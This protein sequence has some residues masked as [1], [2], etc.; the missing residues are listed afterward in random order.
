MLKIAHVCGYSEDIPTEAPPVAVTLASLTGVKEFDLL[1]F[2]L[3]F[4]LLGINATGKS[5]MQTQILHCVQVDSTSGRRVN[6]MSG[7][8]GVADVCGLPTPELPFT[9]HLSVAE[10]LWPCSRLVEFP[11]ASYRL[12]HFGPLFCRPDDRHRRA[13]R[14]S[15][16]Q[17]TISGC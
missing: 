14:C 11:H 16:A 2:R 13:G 9:R 3:E 6:G 15:A 1:A 12:D 17:G 10:F 4:A 8:F 7:T 5:Q